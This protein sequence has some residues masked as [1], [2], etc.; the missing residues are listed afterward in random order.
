MKPFLGWIIRAEIKF[1]AS[2]L[3]QYPKKHMFKSVE[4]LSLIKQNHQITFTDII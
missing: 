1:F 3:L 2:N 4:A